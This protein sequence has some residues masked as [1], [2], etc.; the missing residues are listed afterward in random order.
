[1]KT[2][3][4]VSLPI[5]NY[6]HPVWD[7]SRWNGFEGRADDILICTS[8]KAGTTW[9]QMICALLVFQRADLHLPLDGSTGCHER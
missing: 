1:M 6:N 9:M 4:L 8:Y 5:R 2:F 7:S 3:D